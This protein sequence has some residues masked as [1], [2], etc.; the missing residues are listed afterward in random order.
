MDF[1]IWIWIQDLI[2]KSR[3]ETDPENTLE[4]LLCSITAILHYLLMSQY[5]KPISRHVV[6]KDFVYFDGDYFLWYNFYFWSSI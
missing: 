6:A 4:Y 5:S 1:R 2:P 3:I